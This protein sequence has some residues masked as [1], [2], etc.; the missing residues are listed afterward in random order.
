MM[1]EIYWISLDLMDWNYL[2]STTAFRAPAAHGYSSTSFSSK[3]LP[4]GPKCVSYCQ[5]TILLDCCLSSFGERRTDQFDWG[6]GLKYLELIAEWPP[7]WLFG[8]KCVLGITQDSFQSESLGLKPWTVFPLK[9][10]HTRS[11]ILGSMGASV[12]S[13][14]SS[15]LMFSRFPF[16][17]SLIMVWREKIKLLEW[18]PWFL[19]SVEL[20]YRE[21]VV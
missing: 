2:R 5:N 12:T 14:F 20:I 16:N 19:A 7:K 21:K 10:F 1:G 8:Y 4:R 9:R 18:F 6:F 11:Q 15:L 17:T 13:G 3:Q